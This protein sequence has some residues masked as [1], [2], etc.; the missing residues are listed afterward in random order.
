MNTPVPVPGLFEF[1]NLIGDFIKISVGL[2]FMAVTV[3]IVVSGIRW[4]T[5]GGDQK[6]V[7]GAQAAITWAVGG[8]GFLVLA[9]I[10]LLII[11]AVTG[12]QLTKFDLT[13]PSTAP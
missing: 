13:F 1:Q 4:M 8:I 11:Q 2:A 3:I 10:V 12:A 7:A 6:K 9:W 5:S